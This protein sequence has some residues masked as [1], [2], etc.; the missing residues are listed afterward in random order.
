[1]PV[2]NEEA[3]IA[4][5]LER[6]AAAPTGGLDK[7]IVLVNDCS[8]DGTAKILDSIKHIPNLRVINHTVNGGKGAAI[9]TAMKNVAGDIVIIQDADL[10]YDPNDYPKLV[11]PIVS[12]AVK[13]VYG[14]RNLGSQKWYMA[15][16]NKLL[17]LITNVLYGLR[18]S[19]METCYK[20]M[21]REVF[22]GMELE[23]KRFDVEAELTAKIA[24]RGYKILELP[25]TYVARYEDKKLSP[26][27]GWP[28]VRALIKYRF[29]KL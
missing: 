4:E 12:G 25:I 24:R 14:A 28:A 20:T 8:R 15:A 5:I 23:C 26:M 21:A 22:A 11:A 19:D 9:A 7:E 16:G 27:D 18:I 17:T 3:T 6:V 10:E 29:A 1:M 2:Y 13:V